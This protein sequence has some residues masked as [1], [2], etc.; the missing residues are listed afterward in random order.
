MAKKDKKITSLWL[1]QGV[2]LVGLVILAF[3]GFH[4]TQD[5]LKH[6]AYFKIR[7]IYCDPT[8]E[9]L[10]NSSLVNLKGKNLYALDI[11]AVQRHL[12]SQYPE[13]T[14]L[15]VLK[16]Y[17]DRVLVVAQRRYPVIKVACKRGEVVLDIK[18]NVL[19][20]QGSETP[21]PL[22]TGKKF[23]VLEPKMGTSIKGTDIAT[24]IAIATHFRDHPDLR[25]YS[26][27]EI[28]FEHS[29]EIFFYVNQN[30]TLKSPSGESLAF[31]AL[32]DRLKV[33]IDADKIEEKINM[34]AMVLA[35]PKSD[36]GTIKYVDV[37]FKEAI[38]GTDGKTGNNAQKSL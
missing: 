29:S 8:L 1:K 13:L 31:A 21:L 17:P 23:F 6:S 14:N 19:S 25:E 38:L 20:L 37:R 36:M 11:K 5:W 12:Q 18:G 16:H 7:E 9:F 24:A 34:L 3:F 10:R 15:R 33:I 26:L 22:L 35:E 30:N 2:L 32:T 28:N 4:L 27:E